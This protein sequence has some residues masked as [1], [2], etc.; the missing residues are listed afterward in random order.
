M[1]IFESMSLKLFIDLNRDSRNIELQH[2]YL[3]KVGSGNS[4]QQNMCR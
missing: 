3:K 2:I 4:I 1:E